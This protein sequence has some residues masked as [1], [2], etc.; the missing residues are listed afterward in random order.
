M[1]AM[2]SAPDELVLCPDP[3]HRAG[4][5]LEMYFQIIAD[6]LKSRLSFLGHK[7]HDIAI[8]PTANQQGNTAMLYLSWSCRNATTTEQV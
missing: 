5:L 1:L 4:F 3:A 6:S 2:S 8:V 7:F